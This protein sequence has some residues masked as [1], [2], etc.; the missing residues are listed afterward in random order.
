MKN[1]YHISLCK[2]ILIFS[3]LWAT[4]R[5][6]FASLTIEESAFDGTES[7]L[8]GEVVDYE[9]DGDKLS[10]TLRDKEKVIGT[11]FIKTEEEKES[12]SDDLGY[13]KVIRVTGTLKQPLEN[14]LPNTFNYRKYLY[15]Q[16]IHYL[17]E[18]ESIQVVQE[19][20]LPYQIKNKVANY[21]KGLEHSEYFL[22]F[23]FGDTSMLD[24]SL[25]RQNGI[26]HLF[27][28]SGM[29]ISLFV[30]M[31]TK[32]VRKQGLVSQII[33]YFF[34][35][36][37]VFIVN[38]IPS[39]LRVVLIYELKQVRKYTGLNWTNREICVFVFFLMLIVEPFYL[40]DIGFQYSFLISFCFT[41]IKP[42]ENRFVNLF[43]SSLVAFIVSLP[44]TAI[45]F[46]EVNV[47]SVLFNL[48]FIPY[49]T[50]LFYPACFVVLLFPFFMPI[51]SLIV[52]L[53]EW[54][55]QI[56]ASF[57]I[58]LITIPKTSEVIWAIYG[59]V[60]FMFIRK[61]K[62]LKVSLVLLISL[63]MLIKIWPKFSN[64]SF[65]Y[66][67][68]VGQGDAALFIAPHQKE[69]ILIDT[70]G[71][72]TY[73]KKSW[74]VSKKST[75]QAETIIAFLHSIGINKINTLVLT[76][77]DYDH[78]GNALELLKLL[79]VDKIILN[80]NEDTYL[81]EEIKRLYPEKIDSKL[82]SSFFQIQEYTQESEDE[83]DASLV[84]R[85]TSRSVSFLMM[86]DVSQTVEKKIASLVYPSNII[87]LGHHGS[88]TSSNVSFLA[89]VHPDLAI[90]SAGRD[91]RYHHPSQATLDTLSSLEIPYFNTAEVNTIF[92][93]L[94]P[95]GQY[96][97]YY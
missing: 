25:S 95:N 62:R 33:T 48:F 93:V 34:L 10:F 68:D 55:N 15:Y 23:L 87:K 38:F 50:Y 29:H 70:G 2:W 52:R 47:F 83:N 60:C 41:Y 97:V 91:N 58:G 56:C 81:E 90:I 11:Y 72:I 4:G 73:P 26:S 39:V 27:A 7:I 66:F 6:F 5:V 74:A 43:Y 31:L 82:S 67:L 32:L 59:F 88:Y 19:E 18:A 63:L 8:M 9:I 13:G 16:H 86:G 76:H 46:Y 44:I 61:S 89:H 69:V 14:A 42:K 3:F 80:Q 36:F 17:F 85:I 49:V 75:T 1:F 92:F 28:V 35:S 77:G 21:L 57:T 53:F 12:L 30:W 65:V 20:V 22:A 96:L 84:Y 64:N 71:Y 94:Y 37:N 40:Y 24:M 78:I 45:H 54:I 51:F 79:S